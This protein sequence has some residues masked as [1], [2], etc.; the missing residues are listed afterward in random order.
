MRTLIENATAKNGNTVVLTGISMAAP[1]TQA[2]LMWAKS[3]IGPSWAEQHVHAFVP[4]GGPFNGAVNALSAL[5]GGALLSFSTPQSAL[6]GAKFTC[7]GCK[8]ALPPS[9]PGNASSDI[10]SSIYKNLGGFVLNELENDLT[11]LL[12][13]LPSIYWM[14]TGVDYSTTPPVDKTYVTLTNGPGKEHEKVTASMM[15]TLFRKIREDKKAELFEYAMSVG[16]TEDPGV[17]TH[18]VYSYNVRTFSHLSFPAQGDFSEGAA[19]ELGD[20]DGTV[21]SDSLSVCDRWAS[22]VKSY[23]LPG[24][25]HTAMMSVRQVLDVIVSVAKEDNAALDAWTPPS[26]V[27][28]DVLEGP[29]NNLTAWEANLIEMLDEKI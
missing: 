19:V 15:P 29:T 26:F 22:T 21:H 2:F 7:S 10:L 5:V 4:V 13:G 11:E 16:T 6:D 25:P 27:D 3:T 9:V 1:F 18:C 28:L 12:R 14:S 17:P 24:V 20:G 8:P 23:K